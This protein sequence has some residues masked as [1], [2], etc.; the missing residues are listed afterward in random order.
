M[1]SFVEAYQHGAKRVGEL[2]GVNPGE[3]RKERV[4]FGVPGRRNW[5]ASLENTVTSMLRRRA[6]QQQDPHEGQRVPIFC[7]NKSQFVVGMGKKREKRIEEKRSGLA[8][9]GKDV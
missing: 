5:Q 3:R 6:E 1:P 9:L 4:P 7:L 8:L 2:G